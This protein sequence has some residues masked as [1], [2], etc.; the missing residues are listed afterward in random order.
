FNETALD[1]GDDR[2]LAGALLDG[3]YASNLRA[4]PLVGLGRWSEEDIERFLKVGHNSRATVFGSMLDAF[5]NSTQFMS[6]EDLASI[7]RYLKS[8]GAASTRAQAPFEDKSTV[9]ALDGGDLSAPGA[10]LYLNQCSF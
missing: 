10:G 7:A 3:W 2:Y 4:D 8:L 9:L 6:D 1:D 5:N